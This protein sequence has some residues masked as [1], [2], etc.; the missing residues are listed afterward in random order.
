MT[1]HCRIEHQPLGELATL[2]EE[3]TRLAKRAAPS[4]FTSWGWVEAFVQGFPPSTAIQLVRIWRE[5]DVVGLA[6][7]G[8]AKEVR[9][10]IIGSRTWHLLESGADQYDELT[11][12]HN[13]LMVDERYAEE[14]SR[15]FLESCLSSRHSW[16]ELYLSGIRC[17]SPLEIVAREMASTCPLLTV[18]DRPY[19]WVDLDDLR[20]SGREYLSTLGGGTRSQI[21]RAMKFYTAEFGPLVVQEPESVDEALNVFEE[22]VQVHTPYWQSRGHAGAFTAPSSRQFHERLI[23]Q[24][25]AADEIQL[26]RISAGPLLL[27]ILYN[28]LYRGNVY[29]YQSGF[30]YSEENKKK[31]G[32]VCHTLAIEYN[33]ERGSHSYDFLAG[34]HRYKLQLASHDGTMRW[35]KFQRPRLKFRIEGVLR[36]FRDMTVSSIKGRYAAWKSRPRLAVA[37]ATAPEQGDTDPSDI[38]DMQSRLRKNSVPSS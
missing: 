22:L 31:P 34:D 9:G 28:Y 21:K 36:N 33:L 15:V 37:P 38:P 29:A 5:G 16:D 7:L 17:G 25:F 30:T 27:G 12:E 8:Q 20:K 26:L 35:L 3:W 10:G 6:L 11:V 4:Y 24:R 18:K 13:A 23:R 19:Y 14:A 1:S 2:R 32:L